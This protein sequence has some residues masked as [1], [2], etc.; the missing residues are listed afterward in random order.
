MSLGAVVRGLSAVV[1]LAVAGQ[2]AASETLT[3]PSRTMTDEA[4]LAGT[5]DAGEPVEITGRL[6][7]LRDGPR[8]PAVI[9]LHGANG[10]KSGAAWNW[11]QILGLRG[12]ATLRLDSYTARGIGDVAV[13]QATAPQFMPIYDAYRAVEVLAAMPEIDADRIYLMGFSRGGTATL[14]ASLRRFHDAFGPMA[15]R[16]AGYVPLY[17][18]CNFT[19]EGELN[20]VDAPVRLIHGRLDDWTPLAPCQDYAD[21]LAAEGAD[22]TLTPLDGA[23]HAFD[24]PTAPAL[25]SDSDWKTSRNCHRIERGGTLVNAQTGQPFTYDDA[26]VEHGPH[27]QFNGDAVGVAQRVVL[28]LLAGQGG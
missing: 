28:D 18:A 14:Y 2:A 26:C 4:F 19:L 9:F 13:D 22:V 21:R 6:A 3:I 5:P 7:G 16:I 20:L 23:H 8:Q 15:G 25:H 1:V 10:P 12:Y 27:S 24:D 11:S 17:A